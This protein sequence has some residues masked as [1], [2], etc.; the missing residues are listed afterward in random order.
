MVEYPII[1]RGVV[2]EWKR[3]AD[4]APVEDT[5]EVLGMYADEDGVIQLRVL[6]SA[7]DAPDKPQSITLGDLQ[8]RLRNV[9]Y[10]VIEEA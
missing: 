9:D 5:T 7:P 4:G 10:E 6:D 8:K 1:E 3:P 2:I